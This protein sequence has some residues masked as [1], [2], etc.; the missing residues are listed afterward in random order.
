MKSVSSWIWTHLESLP[1]HEW[2]SPP[3]SFVH[4][5]PTFKVSQSSTIN[6]QMLLPHLMSNISMCLLVKSLQVLGVT[7][8]CFKG[9]LWMFVTFWHG[10]EHKAHVG[11]MINSCIIVGL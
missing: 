4:D 11:F 7:Y 2:V 1:L 9:H 6:P 5:V 8:G 3:C 10:Q